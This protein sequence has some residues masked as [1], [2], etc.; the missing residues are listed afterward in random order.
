MLFVL[1]SGI[2]LSAVGWLGWRLF[3]QDRALERQRLRDRLENAASLIAHELDQRL[4]KWEESLP[5]AIQG[6][7]ASV[8]PDAALLV[9]DSHGVI[10]HQGMS[11]PYYPVVSP[12]SE[13]PSEIFATGEALEFREENFAKAAAAYRSLASTKNRSVRAGALMRLARSLRKQQLLQEAIAVYGELAAL[14]QTSVAG[15]PAELLARR[16]RIALLK[17]LGDEQAAK[18]EAA[19]LASVLANGGF[20]IDRATFNFYADSTGLPSLQPGRALKM[21]EAVDEL[22]PSWQ[23]QTAG[24][25]GW[26]NGRDALG[27]VWRRTPAGAAAIT[28]SLDTLMRSTDVLARNLEVRLALENPEGQLSWGSVPESAAQVVTKTFRET[29]LP[30]TMQLAPGDPAAL[31]AVAASRRNLLFAGFGLMAL[32][33]AAASYVVFRAVSRELSVARLQSEF[34]AAVSHEFRTPLTAM[35]HLTDMLEEGSAPADRLSQYYHALGK[36][37]RRLHAMVESLLD[38][39]RIEAGRRTYHL[40]ETSA[41]ELAERVVDEFRERAAFDAHRLELR[42]PVDQLR[43]R[44]DRDA[45]A[46]AIRNLLDNALKYSPKSSTVRVCVESHDGLAGISV[47]DEGAGIP[48]QEQR[49]VF[50]KFVRGTSAKAL[51]VNG[52]GIGLTMADQIVRAHGGRLE[53]D[54]EPGQGSRFTILLPVIDNQR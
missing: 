53:L 49:D 21:A 5:M 18:R 26:T 9:F 16:E 22:W 44:A 46:L 28:G 19:S 14:G 23:Q 29:G 11:L 7:L 52:T 36:E 35:R 20:L 42:A 30:W 8:P 25:T 4:S 47:H 33:I 39:G 34:V 3:E 41:A 31:K 27:A 43:I 40:E 2:P 38:F 17:Q 50:R 13:A 37:T 1:L 24:R 10:R 54:S 45:L 32:V 51:N 48:K 15:S 12:S 6:E